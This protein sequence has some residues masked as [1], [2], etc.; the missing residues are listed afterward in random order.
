[1]DDPEANDPLQWRGTN[2]LG[3]A[4]STVR[5]AIRASEAGL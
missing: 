3:K 2:L 4:L 1:A 5:D